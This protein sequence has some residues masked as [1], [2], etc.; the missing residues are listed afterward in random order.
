MRRYSIPRDCGCVGDYPGEAVVSV[1]PGTL[2]AKRARCG[3]AAPN[4]PFVV[5]QKAAQRR[6]NSDGAPARGLFR[7]RGDV[8]A[9]NADVAQFTI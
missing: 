8:G 7:D 9:I 2:S 3:V 6:G 4:F 5:S 1:G